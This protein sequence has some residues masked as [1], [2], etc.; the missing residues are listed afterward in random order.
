MIPMGNLVKCNRR[1]RLQAGPA[2]FTLVELLIVIAIIAMLAGLL[3][4]ALSRA[5]AAA[6]AAQCRSQMRQIAIAMRLYAD[7]HQDELPR[8]QH[9]AAARGQLPWGRAIAGELGQ[10]GV[11]WTNLLTGIYH[12]PVDTRKTSWSYGQNVFFELDPKHDDYPGM[13]STWRRI[14]SVPRPAL[15]IL[16]GENAGDADHIMPHF[17]TS[18]ADVTDVEP[19][20]HRTRSIYTFV[21]GH[22]EALEFSRTFSPEKKMDLWNPSVAQ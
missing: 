20:R 22:A 5:K 1:G 13:P 21:D 3:L 9:S 17:W 15:T 8:S 18:A 7:Q 16:Q 12:C 2:G 14:S 19:R 10:P 11:A 4:P 6:R